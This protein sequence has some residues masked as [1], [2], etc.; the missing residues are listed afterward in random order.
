MK[1]IM[2]HYVRQSLKHLPYFRYL[3]F[4]NFKKQLDFFDKKFGFVSYNEFVYLKENPKFLEQLK[5]KILLTFDD[6][7]KDHYTYVYHELKKRKLFGIFFVPTRVFKQ[8]KALDVHRVHHLLGKIGGGDLLKF[9]QKIL[10]TH[11]MKKSYLKLFGA[12]YQELDDDKNSRDFKLL[13]NYFIKPKYKEK[14]LDQVVSHFWDDEEIFRD[15]YLS[16]EELKIMGENQMLL[17]AHAVNHLSFKTLN[18]K[19]QKQEL[20][21]SVGFLNSLIKQP[22]SLF[23]YPYGEDTAYARKWLKKHHFD[24]AFTAIPGKDI[25]YKDLIHDRFRLSRYDC[26]E[27]IHGKAHFG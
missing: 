21:S 16:Q 11:H 12:Y 22:V 4:E 13:L 17:S 1:I 23:G 7:F 26:N 15:L 6:G 9:T 3:H 14:I 10:K 27:F 20:K 25:V 8:N 5:N 19:E 18:L 2:Y 24:F